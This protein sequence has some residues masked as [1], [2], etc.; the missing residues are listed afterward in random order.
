MATK[1]KVEETP[2]YPGDFTSPYN[3][4]DVIGKMR[5][6]FKDV[7][8]VARHK[9]TAE[10]LRKL[11]DWAHKTAEYIEYCKSTDTK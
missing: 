9:M 7:A 6:G 2:T 5:S 11:G 10:H 3:V 1:K 4:I 8:W